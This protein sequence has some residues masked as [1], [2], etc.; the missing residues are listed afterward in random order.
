M[1]RFS[2]VVNASSFILLLATSCLKTPQ[3][4]FVS[5]LSENNVQSSSSSTGGGS[6]SS[7]SLNSSS[8]SV[9]SSSSGGVGTRAT[10][11]EPFDGARYMFVGAS[12]TS[13]HRWPAYFS[14]YLALRYPQFTLH[15]GM[16]ARSGTQISRLFSNNE[17]DWDTDAAI[18]NSH[19]HERTVRPYDPDFIFI[20]HAVSGGYR[21]EIDADH[22]QSYIE[23]YCKPDGIVP[24]IINGWQSAA[25]APQSA[26]S[27][28]EEAAIH[29]RAQEFGWISSTIFDITKSKWGTEFVYTTNHTNN[30]FHVPGAPFAEGSRVRTNAYT[31]ANAGGIL[32][33]PTTYYVK[34]LNG[35]TFQLSLTEGGPVVDITSDA[36]GAS[37]SNKWAWAGGHDSGHQGAAAYMALFYY[38][39][40]SLELDSSVSQAEIN[41]NT[42]QVISCNK[43]TITNVVANALGGIDFKR[44]DERLPYVLDDDWWPDAIKL[45]P[46]LQ[47][48]QDYS[49]K[50]IGLAAGNFAVFA[51]GV[52]IGT[53]SSAELARGWNMAALQ[54]GPVFEKGKEVLGRI[55]DAQGRVR[56]DQSL[57]ASLPSVSPPRGFEKF[58][59]VAATSYNV[60]GNRGSAHAAAVAGELAKLNAL[61]ALIHEAAQPETITFSIRAI[62]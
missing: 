58:R 39:F 1:T 43:C 46:E 16:D 26:Q 22:R 62:D 7:S 17:F 14:A 59:A 53:A 4:Q 31:G 54:V 5:G 52:Q 19:V 34:N 20:Q 38:M 48:H 30:T 13:H 51:N 37:I 45:E 40:E 9:S 6:S 56:A 24:V 44:L 41:A 10:M 55:R 61:D 33:A 36:A 25:P 29:A 42:R 35:E 50:V 49:M 12:A 3:T 28:A 15:F 21:P 11:P 60:N 57:N 18:L 2:R 47:S 23:N 8:S 32:S 27:G